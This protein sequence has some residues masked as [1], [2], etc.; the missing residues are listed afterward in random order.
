MAKDIPT[1][2][3]EFRANAEAIFGLG[4]YS[5]QLVG[6]SPEFSC[7]P[8]AGQS[9]LDNLKNLVSSPTQ[10]F[11]ICQDYSAAL[12][13]AQDF[14]TELLDNEYLLD[15]SEDETLAAVR[16]VSGEG[17]ARELS[18]AEYT[19]ETSTGLLTILLGSIRAT[20]TE[21]EIDVQEECVIR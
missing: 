6:F 7:T 16:I 4:G 19:F 18:Q 5:V 20:D 14:A 8:Q 11:P 12:S 3:A 13:Q 1:M 21:I 15:L 17:T 10:I 9:Y 2:A